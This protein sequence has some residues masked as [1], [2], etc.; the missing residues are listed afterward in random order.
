[1]KRS[2]LIVSLAVLATSFLT[3]CS[4]KQ[5]TKPAAKIIPVKV[6]TIAL[7]DYSYSKNYVG[8]VEESSAVS[9]SFSTMGTVE[10]VFVSE[11][12]KVSKGQLL[13]ALNNNSAQ[14]AYDVAKSTLYQAQDAY[15]RL[16]PMHDKGS[17]TD[18]KF[19]DVETGLEKAK[20]MEAIA[21]KN[22]EDC[23]LYAPISGVIAKRSIEEG[24]NVMPSL[25]AFKLVSIN[26]VN[27]NV[28]VP[29]NE[30]GSIQTGQQA[31][32]TVPAVDN[33]EYKGVVDKKGVEANPVSHT[34]SLKIKT[35]NPKLELMPGM[36]CKVFL[37]DDKDNSNRQII[38]P[39]KCVQ[40]S[41]DNKPFVWLADGNTAK[42][43]FVTVG[44]L[45]DYGI[46]IENGLS[47][48]D[49]LIVEGFDKISEGMQISITE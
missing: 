35:A 12:E 34:Y 27:I 15:N 41:P 38:I 33:S 30:I 16:K 44:S 42:R 5:T 47:E 48:G 25:S 14:N 49:K 40:I 36:V 29:E 7:S 17:I 18:V 8:T 32:I 2:I 24:V 26:E 28:S 46:I 22:V 23:K 45:S 10:R 11:G 6:M 21:K 37:Q 31:K 9:L 43:R 3:G 4:K 19:V 13:A 39:N 20:S 1:M